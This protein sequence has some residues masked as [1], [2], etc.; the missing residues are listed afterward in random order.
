MKTLIVSAN[1]TPEERGPSGLTIARLPFPARRA[2]FHVTGRTLQ[3]LIGVF[4]ER[5]LAL[6]AVRHSAATQKWPV[7]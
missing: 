7:H 2:L 1:K 5:L 4:A 3:Y 6:H